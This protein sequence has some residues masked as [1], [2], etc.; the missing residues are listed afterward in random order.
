[1]AEQV[2]DLVWSLLWRKFNPWPRNF[3]MLW[4]QPKERRRERQTERKEGEKEGKKEK[5]SLCVGG[6]VEWKYDFE[7][8][9]G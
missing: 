1:M 3:H 7:E 4:A 8:R 2:K 6:S 9:R 5:S